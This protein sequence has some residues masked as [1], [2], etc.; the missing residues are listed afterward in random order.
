MNVGNSIDER[1]GKH[2]LASYPLLDIGV[3]LL[4]ILSSRFP[5][6]YLT[7]I[8]FQYHA[9]FFGINAIGVRIAGE[10]TQFIYINPNQ[11]LNCCDL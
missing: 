3:G 10:D 1:I 4:L 8:S 6:T 5:T 9:F 7:K 11:Q 2:L